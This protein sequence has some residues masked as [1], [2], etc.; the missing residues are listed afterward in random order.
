MSKIDDLYDAYNTR[1]D[2][3]AA[4]RLAAY[5]LL[6]REDKIIAI[7]NADGGVVTNASKAIHEDILGYTIDH[8]PAFCDSLTFGKMII[9]YVL[10]H[11]KMKYDCENL[12][13]SELDMIKSL[14]ALYENIEI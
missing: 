8:C 2:S 3:S 7:L 4:V 1:K 11:Y 6:K 9:K 10:S 5:Q 12:S 14:I 13:D